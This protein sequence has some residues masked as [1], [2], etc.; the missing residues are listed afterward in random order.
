MNVTELS[1]FLHGKPRAVHFIGIGGSGMS[2]IAKLCLALGHRVTGSDLVANGGAAKLRQQGAVVLEGHRAESVGKADLVV[3]S[4]AV[5]RD[6][7]EL[8]EAERMHIP[9]VR[10]AFALAALMQGKTGIAISGMHGKT[11]TSAMIAHILRGNDRQPTFCIGAHIPI[12]GDSAESGTGPHFVAEVDESDGT[13]TAFKPTYAV[14]TN[15]E[16]EHLDYFSDLQ[17]IIDTF[18]QFAKQTSDTVFYCADD[19][20]ASRVADALRR[21]GGP[22]LISYGFNPEADFRIA[23]LQRGGF[24]ST[25]EIVQGDQRLGRVTLPIPGEQNVVNACGAVAVALTLGL[26]FDPIVTALGQFT[27]AARRFERKFDGHDILVIDDYA[28][29]PTEIKATLNAAR[30]LGRNR[31]IVAFQPH[32]YTRTKFLKEQFATAFGSADELFLT[33]I[34]AASEPPIEGIDGRSLFNAIQAAGQKSVRYE[35]NLGALAQRLYQAAQPGDAVLILGAGDICKVADQLASMLAQGIWKGSDSM[36]QDEPAIFTEFKSALSPN[37]VVAGNEPMA[38]RTSLRVGG[39]AQ[40]YIEPETEADLAATLRICQR[41]SLPFL[42]I[43]RGSNLLIKDTGIRGAVIRL[44]ADAFT[45][46]EVDGELIHAGA[47][48]KLKDVVNLC[49]QH[50]LAGLEF[51]EG[52]PGSVGGALRMNA[53]AMGQ[54][55]F[56]IVQSV[57]FMDYSGHIDEK[58]ASEIHFEY[59]GCPLF[60]DH[61]ALAATLK[62][63]KAAKEQ[64]MNRLRAFAEK[65]WGSQPPQPSAGCIFKNPKEIPAGKLIEELGLKGTAV[66]K[67]KV[68]DVH[69]NFIVNEGGATASDVLNLI[70]L[71]K[72]KALKERGIQLE[73]E[74]I[75]LGD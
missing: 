16:E 56:E 24:T 72:A 74:V 48:A 19:K 58:R 31:L 36:P 13:L 69:G 54:W 10:R 8:V 40:F 39:N 12:L 28:H 7:P 27:G 5:K 35:A 65:R 66:G 44:A 15:I 42:L 2:G 30:G 11:T 1:T 53:G 41:H 63:T 22:K 75:I 26:S 70:E 17:A 38:K 73:T 46:I 45:R 29:H 61:I 51:L 49:K 71:V 43:G 59:R 34:Y 64:I 6:N 55:T 68:S 57:R 14:I 67:A 62:G 47:G 60:R 52:I 32:R 4:S 23:G 50:E 3:Y 37:A 9:T 33:D 18:T 25:F 20:H 21:K